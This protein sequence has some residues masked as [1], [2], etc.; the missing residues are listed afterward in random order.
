MLVNEYH[1]SD[2]LADCTLNSFIIFVVYVYLRNVIYLIMTWLVTNDFFFHRK[3][4]V[5]V[6]R[7]RHAGS[8]S[9]VL[10]LPF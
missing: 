7:L 1:G 4:I 6:V 9:D 3:R 8:A 2:K 5:I 10:K